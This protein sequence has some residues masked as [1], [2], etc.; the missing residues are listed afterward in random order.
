MTK[1]FTKKARD[2]IESARSHAEKLGHTYIGSEHLLLGIMCTECVA[3]KL[4]DDKKI[5]YTDLSDSIVRISGKGTESP[6]IY[7]S[8]TPKCKK[9]LETASV[10]VSK[11]SGSF[12]GTE[13]ILYAICDNPDCVGAKILVSLGLNI[14]GMKNE[15]CSF[16][17]MGN[18]SQFSKNG[19]IVGAPALSQYGVNLT[20]LAGSGRLDPV[21]ER[22]TELTRVA[23][24]L[25]RR[26][27]NNPCLIG[28][29]GVGKTA[30]A[31]GLAIK[32]ANGD[33]VE[34]LLDKIIVS[35]DISAMVAGAKYRGEFE[36]R[37]KQVIN[38]VKADRRIVLFIDEV[39][40]LVGAGSAEGA[41]DAANIIK[42]ALARGA[43][44]IIGATTLDEYRKHIERDSALE[45]R[46]Q[47]VMINEPT[48]EQTI[49]IINGLKDKYEAFHGLKI[50]DNA[51]K[52]AVELSKRY[53]TDRFLPD[54]AID[55]IDEACSARK[56][57][58]VEKDS[59]LSRLE[60]EIRTL[61]KQKEEAILSE[62]FE[63]ASEIRDKELSCKIELNRVK[64]KYYSGSMPA[65][66]T[67]EDIRRGV[68]QWTG[69]PITGLLEGERERLLSLA[70]RL[71]SR[72]VGQDEA[73]MLTVNA[74]KRGRMGLKDPTRP[75]G[76]FLF[77]GP[78][79]VGKTAL[80]KALSRELYYGKEC[81][82]RLDMSEYAE[83]H[84]ISR[85]IGSPP[86]YVGYDDGGILTERVR[87][88][89]YSVI[90][91]D[92]IEKA[93][94]D[95]YSLLLQI[96]DDGTLTD[97]R[98]RRVD[99]RN[100]VIILTSNLGATHMTQQK[101]LGFS[102]KSDTESAKSI[103]KDMTNTLKS[104]FSP[105]LLNRLDEIII[106]NKLDMS[107]AEKIVIE[108]LEQ[109]KIRALSAG[110]ELSFG[111][112]V[113]RLITEEG[114]D[115]IYGARPLG[116]AII[117]KIDS[118]LS[119]MLL[120]GEIKKGDSVYVSTEGGRLLFRTVTDKEEAESDST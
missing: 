26:T 90:L 38:E 27:K 35:L 89:P 99:F 83:S 111:E 102:E 105:E 36:E 15:I 112:G 46:F 11:F 66:V 50:S 62:S 2:A 64:A 65:T 56:I 116:R 118:P 33:T 3:S 53:I 76:S 88:N 87:K 20:A 91:F 7:C 6:L 94:R 32:I 9:I 18:D 31:E 119:D 45:R 51:I 69:I 59:S 113:S 4:L 63:L 42:P 96:L 106:F 74:I 23:Q 77:L 68:S 49:R 98:S 100:C 78:T 12:I 47:P 73:I 30:I 28:E 40:I 79:G 95:I 44:R 41:V 16:L 70:D 110:I 81:L 52:S 13:H 37:L 22:D 84:T 85:L 92:E 60:N 24:I 71:K 107:H 120:T 114:Y 58:S 103:K 54:K 67:D 5:L 39:H 72:I 55:L 108:M 34:C 8:F 61:Q 80:A 29:P 1:N 117:S 25:S 109:S 10:F 115:K 104:Y 86:G 48:K 82:V 97:S 43:I 17:E 19:G 93:H 14:Q 75:I 101:H 21:Y 57:K